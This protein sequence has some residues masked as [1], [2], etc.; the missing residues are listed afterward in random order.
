MV[1][2]L[3]DTVVVMEEIVEAFVLVKLVIVEAS[4]LV[5]LVPGPMWP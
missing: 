3:E 1:V 4:V 2:A 5:K